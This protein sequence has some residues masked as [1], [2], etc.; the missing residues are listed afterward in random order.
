MFKIFNNFIYY[1]D[2]KEKFCIEKKN[3]KYLLEY[4]KSEISNQYIDYLQSIGIKQKI[5]SD[6]NKLLYSMKKS[7]DQVQYAFPIPFSFNMEIT[8]RCKLRCPQCY[9]YLDSGKHMD[10]K[11]AKKYIYEASKLGINYVNISGGETLEYPYL[12]DIL[13]CC[14]E[15]NITSNIAISGW[16]FDEEILQKLINSGV[17]G[18]YVSLNGSTEELNSKTRDGYK[19]AINALS[20]LNKSNFK[21]YVVNWVAH[22][23]N[24]DDFP[25][26][27]KLLKKYNVKEVCVLAAKPDSQ[28][29]MD[30]A[31]TVKNFKKLGD[32]IK[33][34]KDKDLEILIE[35]CYPGLLFYVNEDVIGRVC[36]AAGR[37]N[38]SISVDGKLTPC[39]HIEYKESFEDIEDYWKNS[40]I[41]KK[42]RKSFLNVKEPC[43]NCKYSDK[44]IP[45]SAINYKMEDDF[46][47]GNKYCHMTN[48]NIK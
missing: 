32:F 43:L 38:F 42:I 16:N 17:G 9:C 21:N 14:K 10:P 22:D 8:T 20:I 31:P 18:I 11:V 1:I 12:L 45:C 41:L 2:S 46:F 23:N 15:N 44:C 47:K 33:N 24:I 25:N 37:S 5:L 6:P 13:L 3:Y 29:K 4:L 30:T 28:H 40:E 27:I 26:L 39:R 19:L 36:C 7:L 35:A 34:Y 48:I